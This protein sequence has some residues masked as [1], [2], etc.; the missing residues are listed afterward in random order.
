M[1]KKLTEVSMHQIA[2]SVVK[3]RVKLTNILTELLTTKSININLPLQSESVWD[4]NII[5]GSCVVG[6]LVASPKWSK[7]TRQNNIQQNG[8]Y[9]GVLLEHVTA[10]SSMP[11]EEFGGWHE[12][13][14]IAVF[15]RHW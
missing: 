8:K 11:L 15:I 2:G 1:Y 9:L 4:T 6:K 7:T 13:I 12:L 3:V 14:M 5:Y 10:R